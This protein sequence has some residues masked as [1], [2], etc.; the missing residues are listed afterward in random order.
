MKYSLNAVLSD[1][2]MLLLRMRHAFVCVLMPGQGDVKKLLC[3]W[4]MNA[5]YF[6]V[7]LGKFPESLDLVTVYTHQFPSIYICR[8]DYLFVEILCTYFSLSLFFGFHIIDEVQMD[9]FS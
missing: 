5:I 7:H 3:F 2:G 1:H 4:K 8:Y 6:V 9:I